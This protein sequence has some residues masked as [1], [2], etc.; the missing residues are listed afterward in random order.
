MSDPA[1]S[2]DDSLDSLV[3]RV[4]DEFLRRQQQGEN[5]DVEEYAQRYPQAASLLRAVLASLRLIDRSTPEASGEVE[6]ETLGDFRLR[7]EIGRGGMG[8]VYE[9]EQI[10]LN[11][12]VALKVLPSAATLD[13]RRLQRF[14]IE[15][16]AAAQLLHPNIVPVYAVGCE[17]GIHFYAMQLIE[18][19]TLSEFVDQLRNGV[20]QGTNSDS[21]TT[22]VQFA[23][24]LTR[25][26]LFRRTA[27]IAAQAADALDHAHQAGIIHRDVKPSNLLLDANG[28]VWITD[29]GLAHCQSDST[30]TLTGDLV[31]T[32]RYMSPE[33]ARGGRTPLDARADVY[34]LGATLYEL[35]TLHPVVD[36]HDRQEILSKITTQEPIAPR[37]LNRNLPRE[38]EIILQ[39]ALAKSPRERYATAAEFADDLR[40]FLEDRPLLARPPNPVQRLRK[41]VKRHRPLTATVGALI[42][43]AALLL[44][45]FWIWLTQQREAAVRAATVHLNRAELLQEQGHWLKARAALER[46]EE[47]LIE[48]G[49]ES[50]RQRVRQRHDELDWVAAL[51]AARLQA[52][53]VR[54]GLNADLTGADRAYRQEFEKRK[55]NVERGDAEATA[56]L[57]QT[58]SIRE[59]LVQALDHWAFV[60]EQLHAGDGEPLLRVAGLLDNDPWRQRLRRLLVWSDRAGLESLADEAAAPKQPAIHIAILGLRLDLH[61]AS[62]RAEQLLRRAQAERPADFWLNLMLAN[63]LSSVRAATPER[64]AESVGFYRAALVQRPANAAVYLNLGVVFALANRNVE[65]EQAFRKVLELRGEYEPAYSNLGAVLARQQRWDEAEQSCNKA[66]GLKPDYSD[67][68]NNLGNILMSR[69]KLAQAEKEFRRALALNDD[70]AQAHHS[71]GGLLGR[72]GKMAEAEKEFRAVVRLVPNN[73]PAHADLGLACHQQG[74]LDEAEKEERQ[75]IALLPNYAEAWFNLANILVER[76]KLKEAEDALR[77]ALAIKPDFAPAQHNLRLL[78]EERSRIQGNESGASK[79]DIQG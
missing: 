26:D 35:L 64:L 51:D 30:L 69:G 15:A 56:K 45:G 65:A 78:L 61:G 25:A 44:G 1:A 72:Q 27:E 77:R 9:A 7:R 57:L 32:L 18:G 2:D 16:Q 76:K 3:G 14:K 73:A 17:R 70:N 12:R 46:A 38:L 40:R 75:A 55:V 34:S 5:P 21:A 71:L 20:G 79:N 62:A 29:F 19:R 37:R 13:P 48:H 54:A 53:E 60:K 6:A 11:R 22:V 4:A 52:T 23:P 36:G 68:H 67:A 47:R 42:V 28:K 58:L 63:L 24:S 74:K 10:S 59:A 8:V 66:I 41:W 43:C 50:L 31:G 39:T 33:Q 49:P